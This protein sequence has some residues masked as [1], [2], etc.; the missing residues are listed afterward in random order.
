MAM[1][2]YPVALILT[3]AFLR[4][5]AQSGGDNTY[6]FLN[7]TN[8]ARVA[9]L[10]GQQISL[11]GDDL[12]IVF[13]NPSLLNPE[14]SNHLV[15]NYINYISDI[16]FGYVSYARTI[17]NYGNFGAGIHYIDYGEFQYAD[18]EGVR[19]GTFHAKD[20]S[21]NL[22]YSHPV[23]DSLFMVGATLKGINSEYESLNSWG[24]AIDAGI[25]YNDPK[26][27]F[28]AALVMKNLGMQLNTYYYN[29][30]H[31]PLPFEIQ[32]GITKKLLHAPFRFSILAQ[33]LET[34]NL[35]YQTEV[36][37]KNQ[38]DLITGQTKKQDKLAN[39]GDNVMRH[40]VFGL[41]FVPA[42]SFNIDIG[43]NYKRRQELKIDQNSGMTGF[44]WGFGFRIYKFHFSYGWMRYH[45]A[46]VANHFSM[47]VNLDEFSRK[48]Q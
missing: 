18:V 21:I 13:H 45:V 29:A 16:N 42:K 28:T 6:D 10:G 46:A 40:I 3:F 25:T 11:Y 48:F 34:P 4:T 23:L 1:T 22:Y 14:M 44:S 33:H 26:N 20:Y 36:D 35:R 30:P 37:N 41:E 17:R 24:F 31:E 47:E 32:L 7:L 43:Y 15:M 38:V 27:E 19:N 9:S 39:F 8:S 5:F 12:N 2:K